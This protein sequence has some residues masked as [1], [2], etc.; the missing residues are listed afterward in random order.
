MI[1]ASPSAASFGS[2]VISTP[3]APATITLSNSGDQPL[4]LNGI[5]VTGAN[6]V[7]FSE[8]DT[9]HPPTVLAATRSCTITVVFTPTATGP[10]AA[11]LSFTD[12][13]PG[14]P[15]T[16]ALTGTGLAPP[17]P[18]GAVTLVPG[19]ITF[20]V[21]SEGSKS[22]PASVTVTNSGTAAL[23]ISSVAAGG[24]NV[25]DFV[26][27]NGCAGT[28][29]TGASCS[30]TV[31]FAPIAAGLR[32]ETISIQDD[33]PDLLQIIR[34]SG[35]ASS[36]ITLSGQSSVT[37]AAGAT[38]VYGLSIVS[39]SSFS[40]S[41][42]LSCSGAPTGAHC[43]VPT[44]VSVTSVS[45][46]VVS[47]RLTTSG[48]AT[49]GVPSAYLRIFGTRAS[50]HTLSCIFALLIAVG[51][52]LYFVRA[53]RSRS[54]SCPSAPFTF[55]FHPANAS[56]VLAFATLT[57]CAIIAGCGGGAYS[58][59]TAPPAAPQVITPQGSSTITIT[60]TPALTSGTQLT[61]QTMKFTLIVQ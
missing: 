25:N 52:F 58:A 18:A 33:A 36:A 57:A 51:N 47:I 17:A 1:S 22:A 16:V 32:S 40:G 29:A 55:S 8:S 11:A 5:V 44:A 45:P 53:Q 38:A 2:V 31:S 48:S 7:D 41:V 24:N 15:Q 43:E 42:S 20:P 30:I 39:A 46:A 19:S 28:I 6:F 34:I 59:P 60:A 23:H 12:N 27:V 56:S 9:C 49:A 4:S 10:R 50:A 61:P 54:P 37:V 26:N 21:I 3:S 14:S 35:N 13:A